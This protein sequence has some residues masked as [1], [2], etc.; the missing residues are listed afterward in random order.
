MPFNVSTFRANLA[1]E[2]Y[3]KNSHYEVFLTPPPSIY[4]SLLNN[5]NGDFSISDIAETMRFRTTKILIP[6]ID[7]KTANVRR[8]GIGPLQKYAITNEYTEFRMEILCDKYG[9]IWQFWYHWLRT[10]F[11]FSGNS[12]AQSGNINTFPGYIANYKNDISTTV[13]VEVFD[14]TGNNIMRFDLLEAYPVA[15]SDTS[16]SWA[17]AGLTQLAIVMNFKEY[18]I[19]GSTVELKENMLERG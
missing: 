1:G 11:Q 3:Q 18:R 16:F 4:S 12:D 17:D 15:L 9:G 8:Y 7:I 14:Q 19:I 10:V 2:G 13:L 5:I 6:G